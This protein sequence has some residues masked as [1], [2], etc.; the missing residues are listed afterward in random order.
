MRVLRN[1]QSILG[2]RV[3]KNNSEFFILSFVGGT[4]LVGISTSSLSSGFSFYPLLLLLLGV[5]LYFSF[6]VGINNVSP[7]KNWR[8]AILKATQTREKFNV[9]GSWVSNEVFSKFSVLIIETQLSKNPEKLNEFI[10]KV[11]KC[12]QMK[13]TQ[14]EKRELLKKLPD[15]INKLDTEIYLLENSLLP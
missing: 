14:K 5:T 3:Y 1:I 12:D 15:E 2:Y 13:K 11:Q 7:Q 4:L 10:Q 6:L 8:V 9:L